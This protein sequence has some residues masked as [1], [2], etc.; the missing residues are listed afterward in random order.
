MAVTPGEFSQAYLYSLAKV[1]DRN[2]MLVV[3][4]GYGLLQIA[5]FLLE[6]GLQV[7]FIFADSDS[8]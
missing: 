1:K 2:T 6:E 5:N 3:D 8:C 7:G 4:V